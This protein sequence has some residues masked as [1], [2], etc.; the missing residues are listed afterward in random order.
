MKSEVGRFE[1]SIMNVKAI[2]FAAILGLCVPAITEIALN[3]PAIAQPKV[4]V[5][6]PIGGFSDGLWYVTLWRENE[7][8]NYSIKNQ[9]TGATIFLSGHE[10]SKDEENRHIYTWRGSENTYQIVW[11]P[12]ESR[13][14][15][16]LVFAADGRLVLDRMLNYDGKQIVVPQT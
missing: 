13:E 14:V 7:A 2:A 16:L 15:R 10:E 4:T 5:R 12:T 1:K 9:Q 11:Q 3:S 8:Y 6:R